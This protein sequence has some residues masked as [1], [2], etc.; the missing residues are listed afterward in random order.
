M[1][2]VIE[3]LGRLDRAG[4]ETLVMNI[5]RNIDKEK[6]QLVFSVNTSYVGAYEKEVESLGGQIYHNPYPADLKHLWMYLRE[7]RKFLRES[8]PFDVVHCHTYFFGGFIMW[9]AYKEG[10]PVRIMHSHNTSDGYK[11]SIQRKIY[12]SFARRLIKKYATKCLACSKEAYESF[13]LEKCLSTDSILNNAIEL[14]N[15]SDDVK[16]I[17]KYKDEFSTNNRTVFISVA[18]FNHVKNHEKIIRIFYNYLQEIDSKSTLLL[19]GDGDLK[20]II[21]RQV[22]DLDITENVIFLN[23]R[24]DVQELLKISDVFLMPSKW[25]GLPVS[26]VEAQAAGVRCV[27]SDSITDDVD[28]G[29]GL[30]F[31]CDI[32]DNAK[33]WARICQKAVRFSRP[34]YETRSKAI[35]EKGYSI[36]TILRKLETLY[37]ED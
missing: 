17:K 20:K 8:G 18:R 10:V 29:L 21:K 5:F 11:D 19:V 1:K 9:A 4:Q 3:V 13:F 2:K 7:F 33:E 28:M 36:N 25:E 34:N 35:S 14:D 30:I 27:I 22:H 12:R 37:G 31:K 6:Y 32:S 26:L 15:Y 16:L 23:V 24:S